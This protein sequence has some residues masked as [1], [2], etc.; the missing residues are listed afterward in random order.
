VS[1]LEAMVGRR[2]ADLEDSQR[3]NEFLDLAA[4]RSLAEE[5]RR[6]LA[7]NPEVGEAERRMIQAAV[8]YFVL[9]QDA[10]PDRQSLLGLDDDLRVLRAVTRHLEAPPA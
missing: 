2:L 8:L 6:L 9:D 4:T 3:R 1:S 7:L 5:S 10:E